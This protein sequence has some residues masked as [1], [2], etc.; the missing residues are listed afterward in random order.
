MT[1][2]REA[3]IEFVGAIE[4]SLESIHIVVAERAVSS[5]CGVVPG[6]FLGVAFGAAAL[7]VQGQGEDAG[8]SVEGHG[9]DEFAQIA[10]GIP[11]AGVGVG[12]ARSSGRVRI[13]ES[14]LNH[15]GIEKQ[16]FYFM[17]VPVSTLV[18]GVAVDIESVAFDGDGGFGHTAPIGAG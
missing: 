5:D 6:L 10:F 1:E 14:G 17:A 3:R 12:P 7:E 4:N 15:T 2:P 13:V 9:V 11:A 16:A 18:G 8:I